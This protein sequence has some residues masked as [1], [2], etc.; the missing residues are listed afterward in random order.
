MSLRGRLER[1]ETT[2]PRK[3]AAEVPLAIKR[4]FEAL[5]NVRRQESGLEPLETIPYTREELNDDLAMIER[6]RDEPGW[7]TPEAEALLSRW[8]QETTNRKVQ[9]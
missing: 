4:Y 6:M 2:V 7:R 3:E 8:E 9:V 1:L 5:E